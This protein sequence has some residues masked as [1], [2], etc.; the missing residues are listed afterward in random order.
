[1]T[2]LVVFFCIVVPMLGYLLK[3]SRERHIAEMAA[4]ENAAYARGKAEWDAWFEM[5]YAM[6]PG[7][8]PKD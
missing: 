1:M 4:I 8:R 7:L 2:Y 3:R 5:F 6:N